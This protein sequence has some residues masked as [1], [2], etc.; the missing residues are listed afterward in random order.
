MI[1]VRLSIF[2]TKDQKKTFGLHSLHGI[3]SLMKAFSLFGNKELYQEIME[4]N[5]RYLVLK[6]K[7][8]LFKNLSMHMGSKKR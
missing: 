7:N 5:L 2:D 1:S 8:L 3:V 6:I 4:I